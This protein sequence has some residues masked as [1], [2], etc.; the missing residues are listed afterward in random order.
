MEIYGEMIIFPVKN[1]MKFV[2][3]LQQEVVHEISLKVRLIPDMQV[4]V[5]KHAREG[6][7]CL[8]RTNFSP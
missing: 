8:K 1:I 6:S 7:S 3:S 5:V 4:F 2:N